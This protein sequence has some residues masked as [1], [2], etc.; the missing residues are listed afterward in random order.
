MISN[1]PLCV[2]NSKRFKQQ[3]DNLGIA[4]FGRIVLTL[5]LSLGNHPVTTGLGEREFSHVR[6][7]DVVALRVV[8]FPNE[9][10]GIGKVIY[11]FQ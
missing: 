8:S 6:M 9:E 1:R 5:L 11:F 3:I 10:Q 7:P 4:C 2:P